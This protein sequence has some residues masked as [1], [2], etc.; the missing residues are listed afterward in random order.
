MS[1]IQYREIVD[2]LRQIFESDPRTA[3]AGVYVEKDLAVDTVG[4]QKAIV[5][6][7]DKRKPSDDQPIAAGRRTRWELHIGVWA[8]GFAIEA[9]EASRIRDQLLGEVELVLMANRTI[10]D[11][12]AGSWLMGGEFVSVSGDTNSFSSAETVLV[13]DVTTSNG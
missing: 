8:C 13:A 11:K 7:L 1:A 4:V 6:V 5:I 9:E 3:D 10:R 12:V 2:S